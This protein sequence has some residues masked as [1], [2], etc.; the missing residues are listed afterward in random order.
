VATALCSQVRSHKSFVR[1]RLSRNRFWSV[2]PISATARQ[3]QRPGTMRGFTWRSCGTPG[4]LPRDTVYAL[5]TSVTRSSA[6]PTFPSAGSPA[7]IPRRAVDGMDVSVAGDGRG[8][9]RGWHGGRRARTLHSGNAEYRSTAGSIRLRRSTGTRECKSISTATII[10]DRAGSQ[11][12]AC[13]PR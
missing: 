12:L 8:R 10:P 9:N 13:D 5:G 1:H 11:S 7:N 2:W 4:N 3:N 6:Q